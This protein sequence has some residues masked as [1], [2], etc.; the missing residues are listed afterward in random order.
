MHKYAHF[1]VAATQHAFAL[2]HPVDEAEQALRQKQQVNLI[3]K[4][5]AASLL[6]LQDKRTAAVKD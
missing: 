3:R 6:M 1:K 2:V 5:V 4:P